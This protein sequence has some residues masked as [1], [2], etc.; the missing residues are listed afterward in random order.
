MKRSATIISVGGSLI[1][2]DHI[3]T[4]FLSA[5]KDLVLR[6]VKDA[7]DSLSLPAE[8]KP[9]VGIRMRPTASRR[10]APQILIGWAFME[11]ASML[12]F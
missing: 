2:P 11:R 12:I 4:G 5:L 1:V 3:D 6:R 9:P 7:I 10:W 8:E